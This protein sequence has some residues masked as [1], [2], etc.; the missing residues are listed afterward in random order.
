MVTVVQSGD[1]VCRLSTPDQA[2]RLPAVHALRVAA[3]EGALISYDIPELFQQR[4]MPIACSE[5]RSRAISSPT[6]FELVI[7]PMTAKTLGGGPA[8]GA[9]RSWRHLRKHHHF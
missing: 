7:N 4:A 6:K 1:R 3:A 5:A 8:G 9:C 2:Y